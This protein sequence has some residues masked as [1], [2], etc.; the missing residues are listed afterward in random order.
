[1]SEL[2]G[3]AAFLPPAAGYARLP[4]SLTVKALAADLDQTE[5][6]ARKVI[7]KQQPSVGPPY[8]YPEFAASGL[9]V[10]AQGPLAAPASGRGP[11]SSGTVGRHQQRSGLGSGPPGSPSAP[12]CCHRLYTNAELWTMP[13]TAGAGA[14][15]EPA[16]TAAAQLLALEQQPAEFPFRLEIDAIGKDRLALPLEARRPG[17][18]GGGPSPA[19]LLA[20]VIKIVS[21]LSVDHLFYVPPNRREAAQ[22]AWQPYESSH[23]DLFFL[24]NLFNAFQGLT[25][26]AEKARWLKRHFISLRALTTCLQVR[27]QLRSLCRSLGLEIRS[28]QNRPSP[29][30]KLSWP[31]FGIQRRP[32]SAVTSVLELVLAQLLGARIAATC[33]AFIHP[34]SI[35]FASHPPAVMFLECVHTAKPY[36]RHVTAIRVEQ[37]HRSKV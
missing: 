26:P 14:S 12:R 17:A 16:G 27:K 28:C 21:L 20:E 3:N 32:C 25:D 13:A 24:L 1:M 37:V 11:G 30:W 35:L 10:R 9:R 23:G 34:A 8:E 29:L 5:R 31:G 6:P 33:P 2:R 36:M 18:A 15:A 4:A 7:L 22:A 19:E